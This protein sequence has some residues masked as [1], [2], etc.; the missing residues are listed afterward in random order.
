MKKVY[1]VTIRYTEFW[2]NDFQTAG[3]FADIAHTYLNEADRDG[4]KIT[5]TFRYVP[6]DGKEVSE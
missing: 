3:S 5:L 2:F 1:V 6:D 4:T